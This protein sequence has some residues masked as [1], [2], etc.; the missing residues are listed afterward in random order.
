MRVAI[1]RSF[2]TFL[3]TLPTKVRHDE[4]LDVL[5][6]AILKLLQNPKVRFVAGHV[7]LNL[8]AVLRHNRH[9]LAG[10]MKNMASIALFM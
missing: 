3:R 4:K 1:S 8:I 2:V 7:N 9:F 6:H 10:K 5:L